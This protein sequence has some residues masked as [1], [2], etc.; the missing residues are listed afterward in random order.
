GRGYFLALKSG[1]KA[2]NLLE[3]M[4][5]DVLEDLRVAFPRDVHREMVNRYGY[6]GGEGTIASTLARYIEKDIIRRL[7]GSLY[8]LPSIDV[9]SLMRALRS[10]DRTIRRALEEPE[11]ATCPLDDL[12]LLVQYSYQQGHLDEARRVLNILFSRND[13]PE[14]QRRSYRRLW[15]VIREK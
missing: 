12:E 11:L 14:E 3:S 8:C 13:L 5:V 4:I 9:A 6:R 10:H 15:T 1:E 2:R 7:P